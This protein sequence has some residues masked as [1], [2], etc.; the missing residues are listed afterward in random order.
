MVFVRANIGS[1][2]KVVEHSN[3]TLRPWERG[4]DEAQLHSSPRTHGFIYL[5]CEQ[6]V[7]TFDAC[8]Q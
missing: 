6:I 8:A 1:S 4:R 5:T 2:S 7:G 3:G